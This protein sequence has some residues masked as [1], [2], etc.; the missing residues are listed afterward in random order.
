MRKPLDNPCPTCG[1]APGQPCGTFDVVAPGA[2]GP[3]YACAPHV[4]REH[5]DTYRRAIALRLA[6]HEK[7]C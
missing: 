4:F 5:A 3:R 7:E 6:I 1:A 2:R